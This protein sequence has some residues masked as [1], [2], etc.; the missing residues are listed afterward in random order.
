[1]VASVAMT[2]ELSQGLVLRF[3]ATVAS[4]PVIAGSVAYSLP[5]GSTLTGLTP[6]PYHGALAEE[7]STVPFQ[8]SY[9]SSVA[10]AHSR[11]LEA[12]GRARRV[13]TVL[14]KASQLSHP[15][16]TMAIGTKDG[17]ARM[18][19]EDLNEVLSQGSRSIG[20]PWSLRQPHGC[21][22]APDT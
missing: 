7:G 14:Q 15:L 5:Q 12:G 13:P 11:A 20:S 6:C 2:G 22:R 10:Q 19:L 9:A 3:T 8:V 21:P 18:K 17:Q 1:M 4:P 16:G